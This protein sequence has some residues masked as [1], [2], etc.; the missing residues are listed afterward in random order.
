MNDNPPLSNQEQATLLALAREAIEYRLHHDGIL[1]VNPQDYGNELGLPKAVFV[2]LTL[3]GELRGC[4]GTLEAV[5]PLVNAVVKYAQAAAF[6]DPRF[7]PVNADEL[8]RLEIH[9]SILSG[10]DAITFASES[11]LLDQIRPGIDGLLLEDGYH[12]GTLLPSVWQDIPQK[13]EFL[14]RLKN[15]A[16][17]ASDHWS[18]Q[19]SV[20]RYTAF[21]FP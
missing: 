14:R 2:T 13:A 7:D 15:K 12:R 6:S 5:H 16:G 19:L 18:N 10:L 3:Q 11:D 9:I 21:C 1:P 8:K 4:I 20:K 17:L